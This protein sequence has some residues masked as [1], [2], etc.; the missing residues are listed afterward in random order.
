MATTLTITLSGT[1]ATATIVASG[2]VTVNLYRKATTDSTWVLAGTRT[3]SGTIT[4][5]GLAAGMQYIFQAIEVIG[6][7]YQLPSNPVVVATELGF[8]GGS[9]GFGDGLVFMLQ[10]HGEE[11]DFYPAGVGGGSRAILALVE[12]LGA[13][14]VPGA[15]EGSTEVFRIM[16]LNDP[17]NGI[18]TTEINCLKSV[19]GVPRRPGLA[20]TNRVVYAIEN[21]DEVGLEFM[22]A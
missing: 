6:G 1:T 18:S 2:A 4:V 14:A 3:G 10:S 15:P 22:A 17:V 13:Q 21:Q 5:S 19:I 8:V 9:Q 12:R 20:K 16:A 11:V 7:Q